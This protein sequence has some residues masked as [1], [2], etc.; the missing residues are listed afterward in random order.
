MFIEEKLNL[1]WHVQNLSLH[2]ARYSGLF[3]FINSFKKNPLHALSQF[4]C[5]EM[6]YG[7][8]L[9]GTARKNNAELNQSNAKQNFEDD[10]FLLFAYTVIAY[11]QT[12]KHF[13]I[14]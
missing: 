14:G 11:L 12:I 7:I 5:S 10:A 13:E 6:L 8:T 9:C 2:L 4:K 1:D 3:F